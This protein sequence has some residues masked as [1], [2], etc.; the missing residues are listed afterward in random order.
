MKCN[1]FRGQDNPN[2]G[3][4]YFSRTE[5]RILGSKH[6]ANAA[7]AV[8]RHRKVKY[9]NTQE[10]LQRN[11]LKIYLNSVLEFVRGM[12]PQC[13]PSEERVSIGRPPRKQ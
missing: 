13:Q 5:T 2:R 7:V 4:G 9:A 6:M 3:N 8:C 1:P 11:L 10:Q 12:S